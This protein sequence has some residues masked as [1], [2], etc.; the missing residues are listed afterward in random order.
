VRS[1]EELRR[2]L[3]GWSDPDFDAYAARL[4]EAPTRL[5]WIETPANP[6]WEITD[7]E[8]AIAVAGRHGAR[9]VVDSTCATPVLTRPLTLG[10]DLVMHSATKYLNGHS[11]VVAGALVARQSDEFWQAIRAVRAQG[12]AVA[13]P[14]ES[15]LLQRGMRTLFLRVR[16]AS[17]NA[18]ALAQWLERQPG[19]AAVA[20][21]GLASHAGHVVAA[22]Q[23]H[24]GFGGMLSV[25]I[26]GGAAAADA[27]AGPCPVWAADPPDLHSNAVPSTSVGDI[28]VLDGTHYIV[29]HC[30]FE[31][32]TDAEAQAIIGKTESGVT[33]KGQ[34][35]GTSAEDLARAG[36]AAQI[37]KG[38]DDETEA[39]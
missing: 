10:A 17:A 23:M 25:R 20:Y 15:W 33:L 19:V 36:Y 7:L 18:L 37:A 39:V 34:V 6:T 2:A 21:P 13:G 3:P 31:K 11:D 38:G 16:A 32:L 29:D 5:L 4:A 9:V 35:N 27:V 22:R 28:M 30:G 8:H 26:A 14:F 24:G 1:Q 12:G